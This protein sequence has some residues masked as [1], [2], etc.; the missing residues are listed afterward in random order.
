MKILKAVEKLPLPVQLLLLAGA[1]F[2]IYKGIKY[3]MKRTPVIKPLPT[4][5]AGIPAVGF[6]QSGKPVAWSAEPLA[7]QLFAAFDGITSLPTTKSAAALALVQLPTK[8]ML[9]AVYNTFNQKYGDGDTLTQ[10]IEDEWLFAG[11]TQALTKLRGAG[12]N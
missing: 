7:A 8:D 12:L 4:G 1:G 6:D 2:G 5:G 11:Q 10:W 9:T 3:I